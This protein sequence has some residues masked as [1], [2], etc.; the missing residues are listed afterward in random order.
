MRLIQFIF[1]M[2]LTATANVSYAEEPSG[3][4][5]LSLI[6]QASNTAQEVLMSALALTGTPYKFGGTSPETGFDCS[7]F[8]SYVFKQAANF[9]LPHGARAISQI[10]Q[11]I[12]VDQLQPGDLVFFNTLKSTFSHVGIYIGDNRF[13][14][15]PSAGGGVSVVNMKEDYWAKRFTGARRL[16][17]KFDQ[18][19]P[20]NSKVLPSSPLL[21]E[22]SVE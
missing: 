18:K 16:N 6:E 19:S 4:K 8:V 21:V 12:P 1:L 2:I 20:A 7:G 11:N 9:T 17:E 5:S 15:A 13:V 10:G 14:H 22:S 3:D